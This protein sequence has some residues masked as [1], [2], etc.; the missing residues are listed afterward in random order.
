M[1]RPFLF[2]GRAA[3]GYND[4]MG[5]RTS[6]MALFVVASLARIAT[7]ADEKDAKRYYEEGTKAYDLGQYIEAAKDYEAAY[8]IINAP[9]LLF[10]IAQ[11]YRLGDDHRQALRSYRAYLRRVPDSANRT[12]VEAKIVEL[13]KL[14]EQEDRAKQGAPEGTIAPAQIPVSK[15]A[16]VIEGQTALSPAPPTVVVPANAERRPV[17]VYKKWWLWT[18]VG[19]AVAG[20][21]VGLGVGLSQSGSTFPTANTLGGTFKW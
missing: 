7:A 19:V 8:R 17:P 14:I 2:F 12:E 21:A 13:Q 1:S 18:I 4:A 15:P 11:A 5:M 20:A 10:N 3:V 16:G 6:L 9:E